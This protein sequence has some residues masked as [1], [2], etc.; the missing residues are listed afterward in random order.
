MT[1]MICS[2]VE[3]VIKAR[4][5]EKKKL[6]SNTKLPYA[7]FLQFMLDTT[8]QANEGK[9]LSDDEIVANSWVKIKIKIPPYV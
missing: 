8:D 9:R 3:K 7:D 1:Q 4:R 6:P 5:E 2:N